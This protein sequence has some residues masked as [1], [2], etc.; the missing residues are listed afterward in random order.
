M[1]G[2]ASVG[3][4]YP[5]CLPVGLKL[6]GIDVR[7]WEGFGWQLFRNRPRYS[8][9][10]GYITQLP[11]FHNRFSRARS[12][13]GGMPITDAFELLCAAPLL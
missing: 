10:L 4:H 5:F 3:P 7:P 9:H 8:R 13:D 12:R 11:V 2:I 1:R 6:L